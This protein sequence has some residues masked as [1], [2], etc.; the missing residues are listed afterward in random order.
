[1]TI[2]YLSEVTQNLYDMTYKILERGAVRREW[3]IVPSELRGVGKTSALVKLAKRYD[4]TIITPNVAQAEYIKK[5]HHY[6]K[7]VSQHRMY[8]LRGKKVKLVF[9]EGVDL[10][11][12]DGFEV[13][14]GFVWKH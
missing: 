12:L 8:E 7:V 6:D 11:K 14:T 1:M 10:S 4:L 13:V 3:I 2:D 5:M 9:E